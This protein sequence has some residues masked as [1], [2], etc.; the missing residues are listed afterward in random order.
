MKGFAFLM[1][2]CTGDR[3]FSK[4][5]SDSLHTENLRTTD[6]RAGFFWG[7]QSSLFM[8]L[9]K[10]QY[11]FYNCSMYYVCIPVN[12]C[13]MEFWIPTTPPFH[14]HTCQIDVFWQSNELILA[15]NEFYGNIALIMVWVWDFH[16]WHFQ[17]SCGWIQPK[18]K[19][20]GVGFEHKDLYDLSWNWIFSSIYFS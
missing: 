16:W 6:N 17:L 20:N 9:S 15:D 2:L 5:S 10:L 7:G 3:I 8:F 13:W 14:I 1:E 4:Y 12:L 18:R 19:I 11:Y